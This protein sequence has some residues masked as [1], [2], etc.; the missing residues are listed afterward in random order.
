MTINEI[1]KLALKEDIP[2]TDISSEYL[3]N[4]EISEGQFIAKEDGV[5]S[6]IDV[7]LA[8]FKKIDESTVFNIIAK[9]SDEVKKDMVI[10]TVYGKTKSILQAERVGLNFLQRMSGI[11]SMTKKFVNE[12]KGTHTKI[13]DTRKT[14]PLLRELEKRAV[15]DGGGINHRMSLSD[16]VMLKDNHLKASGGIIKA[17]KKVKKQIDKSIQIE[18]EVESLEQLKEALLSEADVIMLDN[19]SLDMMKEAVNINNGMKLLE[20]SGNMVLSRIKE[21]SSTGV[22]YISVGALT[23]SYHSMDISLKF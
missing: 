21:V 10:A 13:L 18:V 8:V 5:I 6:G 23:H 20:A 22:D 19:M 7:C 14:T 3:F 17:V 16:M 9:N 12:T 4:D 2:T 1:I 15:L 11:A